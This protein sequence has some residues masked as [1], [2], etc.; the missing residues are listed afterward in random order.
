MYH[1]SGSLYNFDLYYIYCKSS[2]SLNFTAS[3]FDLNI[4]QTSV[5][6]TTGVIILYDRAKYKMR[7]VINHVLHYCVRCINVIADFISILDRFDV[8]FF[9]SKG[10][11]MLSYMCQAILY[12]IIGT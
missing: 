6:C 10:T 1:K 5:V 12:Q 2:G 4:S 8:V 3:P 11:V 9:L 7:K